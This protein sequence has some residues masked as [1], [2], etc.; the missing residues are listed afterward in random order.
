[1]DLIFCLGNPGESYKLTRHN[2]AWLWAE[3]LELKFSPKANLL[4]KEA[5]WRD[6][7]V[8]LPSTY[9][10]DSGSCVKAA[11]AL[12]KPERFIIIYDDK[13]LP[14]GTYKQRLSGSAGSHNGMK[15]VINSMNSAAIHRIKIGIGPKPEDQSLIDF[16]LGEFSEDELARL[17]T[18]FTD[19]GGCL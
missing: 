15:S 4:G 10:N 17:R 14:L 5:N 18:I 3:S 6:Y 7:K 1:L 19:M 2:A 13:D 11:V 9:M 12:Y 8:I 16:V